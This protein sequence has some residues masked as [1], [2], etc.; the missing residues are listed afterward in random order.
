MP[1]QIM[2]RNTIKVKVQHVPL[3]D[4]DEDL[5]ELFS[6]MES[7]YDAELFLRTLNDWQL[8]TLFFLRYLG[9]NYREIIKIM[10]LSTQGKFYNLLNQLKVKYETFQQESL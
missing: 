3:D 5:S 9:Y 2:H 1:L 7:S 4:F 10:H 8:S 6:R